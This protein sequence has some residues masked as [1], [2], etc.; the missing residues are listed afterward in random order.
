MAVSYNK[1]WKMMIDKRISKTELTHLAG[2]STNAMAKL[3]RDEDVR[4]RVLEKLCTTLDC[5]LDDIV[6]FVPNSES[7]STVYFEQAGLYAQ[8]INGEMCL[9][10][11]IDLTYQSELAGQTVTNLERM[12]MGY[13]AIDPVTGQPF[14]LHHIGQAVDSPLAI[15]TPFEHTGGGNNLILHDVNI[16]AGQGVHSLISNAEWTAQKIEFWQAFAEWLAVAA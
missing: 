15:L 6:E 7:T 12:R 8:T 10:R 16:E 13:A 9:V 2:I 3:G 1:L 4:V 11:S 14:Q 5:T